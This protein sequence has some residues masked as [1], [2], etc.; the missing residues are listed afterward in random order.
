ME[1]EKTDQ[2]T[3]PNQD[4]L[5]KEAEAAAEQASEVTEKVEEQHV[6][7]QPEQP[8]PPATP[9][10][11]PV[12]PAPEQPAERPLVVP[13]SIVEPKQRKHTARNVIL[14][15]LAILILG[16][17][18]AAIWFFAYYNNSEKVATDALQNFISA[19][20]ISMSASYKQPGNTSTSFEANLLANRHLPASL[21]ISTT[22][23]NNNGD[24][25]Q[26]STHLN[27][28]SEG[29][30][31][32]DVDGI[33]ELLGITEEVRAEADALG[34]DAQTVLG[35]IDDVEAETWRIDIPEIVN[36]LN[37]DSEYGKSYTCMINN[38]QQN[39]STDAIVS[40]YTNN[41]FF[42][43]KEASDHSLFNNSYDLSINSTKLAQFLND[44]AQSEFATRVQNCFSNT[45][46]IT[47]DTTS[48]VSESDIEAMVG[49]LPV[50]NIKVDWLSHQLTSL[51]TK[52]GDATLAANFAYPEKINIVLPESYR[53]A[54]ELLD[55]FTDVVSIYLGQMATTA[56]STASTIDYNCIPSNDTVCTKSLE[57]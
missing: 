45:D 16:C 6:E 44:I 18:G 53:D 47:V 11:Q 21:S 10:A 15:I 7:Q 9:V 38:I 14:I 28:D 46:A 49:E 35:L 39:S 37:L 17:A 12:A 4:E 56:T 3:T 23:D 8:V 32:A 19:E 41:Q 43:I 52:D 1:P 31:Y 36:E 13:D 34:E 24:Q 55:Q 51:S 29:V 54:T 48:K 57:L 27:I 20:N 30:I 22:I 25:R 5:I 2:N 40:A 50:I 26:L 33:P 42:N